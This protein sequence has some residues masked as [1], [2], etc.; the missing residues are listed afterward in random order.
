MGQ[1]R[2]TRLFP[3]SPVF[4][5]APWSG[6]GPGLWDF[7][8]EFHGHPPQP[9]AGHKLLRNKLKDQSFKDMET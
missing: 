8:G 1:S 4:Q 7:A 3:N 2:K 5:V 6:G 9:K